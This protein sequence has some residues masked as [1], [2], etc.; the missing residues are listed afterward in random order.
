[1]IALLLLTAAVIVCS[2]LA[3]T[4]QQRGAIAIGLVFSLQILMLI[5]VCRA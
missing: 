1:M 3:D 2:L 4:Q 5:K